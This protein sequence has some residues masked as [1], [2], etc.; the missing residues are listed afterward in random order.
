MSVVGKRVLI[1]GDSLSH[2]GSDSGPEAH[3]YV[4]EVTS[5]APG[6]VLA[7]KLVAGGAAAARTDARV[8]RSAI[9][10]WSREDYASL[11]AADRAWR[12]DLVIVMLGTN[13]L[14]R[15][16]QADAQA[17]AGLRDVFQQ[18]GA[19]VIAIGPPAFSQATLM[20]T[21]DTVYATLA[22]VFG[23]KNVIDA[24]PLTSDL[25][26]TKDNVHFTSAGAEIA[27]ERLAVAVE[28]HGS[29]SIIVTGGA[30]GVIA[31]VLAIGVVLG[32]LLR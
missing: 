5:S 27:G 8:G 19:K 6:A 22:K 11:L 2:Y 1:F 29:P 30:I 31:V 7:G 14:G 12:P 3:E 21:T 20:T 13:D 16:A 28:Q 24:R 17:F 9:N 4:G 15:D 32:R 23:A 26:R 18:A 25:G 10:F